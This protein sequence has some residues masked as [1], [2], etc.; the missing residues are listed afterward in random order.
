MGSPDLIQDLRRERA[1]LACLAFFCAGYFFTGGGASQQA[2]YGTMRA[3]LHHGTFALDAA[4]YINVDVAR[5]NGHT[6]SNKPPGVVLVM[7]PAA[8]A[9]MAGGRDWPG[10]REDVVQA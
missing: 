2:H 8:A 5:A 3:L 4:P 9:G 1:L 6:Y 7:L 10:A